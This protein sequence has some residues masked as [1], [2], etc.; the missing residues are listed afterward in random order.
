MTG[1]IENVSDTAFWV[2]HYRAAES[3]RP[4]ALFRDPLAG[5]LAGERGEKIAQAMPMSFW[6]GWSVAVRTCIID[7]F[8]RWAIADGVDT[9]L[10]LG[11]GLDTRPYRMDLPE[12]LAW[13]EAD[14]PHV[15]DFKQEKLKSETPRCQLERVKVDLADAVERRRMLAGINARAQK[16]M[17]LTEGVILYL[18]VEEVGSL[19]EDLKATAHVHYWITEYLSPQVA[20]RQGR[21]PMSRHMQ[22]APM[23]F[24]P[25]DWFGF[26]RQHGWQP[27]ETRYLIDESERLQRPLPVPRAMRVLFTIRGIFSSR[28]TRAGYRKFMAYVMLE[29]A[30]GDS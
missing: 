30:Q 12:S 20:K 2:A 29:R 9:V 25:S 27:R 8:I 5:V 7:D 15:I 4:D 19:A 24:W 6:M 13:I 26:F 21:G 16:M 14:Y 18:S 23:K 22:N 17:V 1:L 28:K 11:A 3:E 10:N